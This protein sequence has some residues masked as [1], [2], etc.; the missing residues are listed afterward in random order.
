MPGCLEQRAES[1]VERERRG[2]R[3]PILTEEGHL[4]QE[5]VPEL[6]IDDLEGG[7]QVIPEQSRREK[8]EKKK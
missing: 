3:R 1:Q 6:G 4:G 2:E 5:T 8:I 7:S